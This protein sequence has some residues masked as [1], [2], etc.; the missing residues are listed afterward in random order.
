M[1]GLEDEQSAFTLIVCLIQR[2]LFVIGV[3]SIRHM[4]T[5]HPNPCHSDEARNLLFFA[6]K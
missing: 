1:H 3:R 4:A 6:T 2:L 5:S